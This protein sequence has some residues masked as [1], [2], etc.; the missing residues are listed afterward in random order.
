EAQGQLVAAVV[1][2]IEE[3]AVALAGI[4]RR[5][6][7]DIGLELDLAVGIARRPVEIHNRLVAWM[8]RI[9]GEAGDAGDLHIRTAIPETDAVGERL[10]FPNVERNKFGP[11]H[12]RRQEQKR[13]TERERRQAHDA[14]REWH[15]NNSLDGL[16]FRQ[17]L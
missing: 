15:E 14:P 7:D 5:Q 13:K 10:A 17:R 16:S 1:D 8:L 6:D 12:R 4:L 2:I 3:G 9:E 11:Q